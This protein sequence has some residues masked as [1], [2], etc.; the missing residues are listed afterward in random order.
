M[1]YF[2]TERGPSRRLWFLA[3]AAALVLHLGGAA[4]ALAHLK[5]DENDG[6]GANGAEFA[7]EMESPKLPDDNLPP[8]PEADPMQASHQQDKQKA[9]LKETDLPTDKPTETDD[10]DRVV[11]E[12]NSKK[13]TEDDPKVATAQ[14]EAQQEQQAQEAAAPQQLADAHEAERIRAPNPGVGKDKLKLTQN[15]G[16]KISAYFELHKK[17]PES[18][19]KTTTV[20]VSLVINRKGNIVS[21]NIVQSSGDAV[22]DNAALSMV[23]RSDPVPP[24][25]AGLTDDQFNFDLPVNFTKPKK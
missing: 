24:P 22:F 2:D 6:L 3:A 17:Y 4:L 23:H 1:S 7:V 18:K 19:D 21:A 14:T 16:R 5:G 9:E 11:S 13:P 15:W 8:G 20:K 25:P 12:N 10:P